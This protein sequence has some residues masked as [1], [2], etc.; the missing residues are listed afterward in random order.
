MVDSEYDYLANI[1]VI[2]DMHVGKACLLIR[3]VNNVFFP[4]H[5]DWPE[6]SFVEKFE[7]F[8]EF[9]VK[10]TIWKG[11]GIER[12]AT[13]WPMSYKNKEIIIIV[14]DL[15]RRSTFD[16]IDYWVAQTKNYASKDTN[17]LLIGNKTDLEREV[18]YQEAWK[19][20]L[21]LG[22]LYV[23]TSAK[24]GHQVNYAFRSC[25]ESLVWRIRHNYDKL[26]K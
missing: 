2:G 11:K 12:I 10:V 24:Y 23:E 1:L 26:V 13:F 20:A 4:D 7:H 17:F 3:F 22:M 5:W 21:M 25:L 19:K 16:S 9:S 14:F 6:R 8:Y 15:S 18:G